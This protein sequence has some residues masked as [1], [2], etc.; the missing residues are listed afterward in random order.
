V[1]IRSCASAAPYYHLRQEQRLTSQKTSAA[2]S[3]CRAALAAHPADPAAYNN[4]GSALSELG[5]FGEAEQM[6]RRALELRPDYAEAHNNLGNALH[7]LGR[8]SDALPHYR[9]TV[10]LIPDSAIAHNNFGKALAGLGA[11]AEAERSLRRAL[12]LKPDFAEGHNDLGALYQ[13]SGRLQEATLHYQRALELNPRFSQARSN[14]ANTLA[15]RGLAREAETQLRLELQMNPNAADVH[16]SLGLLLRDRGA[17]ED[18]QEC[19]RR[20][21]ALDPDHAGARWALAMAQLPLVAESTAAA[22]RGV[23]NF[24]SEL[25]AL[26][27][28]FSPERT[29]KGWK[30]V[31]VP[32]PFYLAYQEANH[33]E[34]MG[35]YGQLCARLL[36]SWRQAQGLSMLAPAT[37]TVIRVG[38]V[39][40]H[41]TDHSVWHA[42]IKGW[43]RHFDRARI[44][45]HLFAVDPRE[46]RETAYA[47]SQSAHF[48]IG[49]RSLAHW[50]GAIRGQQL[51][52]LIYP[53]IGMHP[54]TIKLASLRLAPV[55]A[56]SWGHPETTGLPT[57]DYFLSADGLEPADAPENY[58]ER[59]IA[60]PNLGCCYQRAPVDATEPDLA[61]LG[62]HAAVPL[63]IC[64]GTPFKYAPARDGVLVQIARK[65]GKCQFVFFRDAP[66][67][68]W[69]KL[70]AR[71]EQVFSAAGLN[72]AD[73]GVFVPWQPRASFH[74]LMKRAAAFLDTIGFSGFNTAMQAVECGLPIVTREG[75][76]MRGRL[77]SGILK[78]IDLHEL[79]AASD[80]DYVALAARIASD[81]GYRERIRAKLQA[82][83][84]ILYEDTTPVRALEDF[85]VE[86][87]GPDSPATR[88]EASRVRKPGRESGS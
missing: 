21:L 47:K 1:Q 64:P 44:E 63:L 54:M 37:G 67:G 72:F 24:A 17:I 8:T 84:P 80:E 73:Y 43:L 28:W 20:A 18:A 50:A 14:L 61:G 42:L 45:P 27:R 30:A 29:R 66:D 83:R 39:S 55:Q 82:N 77:A 11:D 48:E 65:L 68:L 6:H 26:E 56:A 2:E 19:L 12:E 34:L 81:S 60:L 36:G 16:A 57:I 74:G 51:H 15:A 23:A 25:S 7:A 69:N 87:T 40:A 3:A 75:R 13:R 46:D 31:G 78:R 62:I 32:A 76:F 5:R 41:F 38:I 70:H 53:E 58:T 52:A 85:L 71:L 10:E 79:I 59:L 49:E 4:L 86:V 88:T 22:D 9:R 33:R 35:R